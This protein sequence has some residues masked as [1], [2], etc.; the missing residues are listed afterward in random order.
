MR[1]EDFLNAAQFPTITFKGNQ[2]AFEGD[3]LKSVSGDLN[4]RG[5]SRPVT[6]NAQ[7]F[8]C[9]V[10][11][12][13]KKQMCGGEFMANIKRSDWG[14]KYAIPNLADEMLLRINIEAY[15]D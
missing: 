9:R 4:M 12:M 6:L 1:A 15:R 5:V 14:I 7:H 13:T 10:H 2:M 8:T 3:K 11:P